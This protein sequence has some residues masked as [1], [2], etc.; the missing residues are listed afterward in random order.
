[1]ILGGGPAGSAAA[2]ALARE[3][4]LSVAIIEKDV[5]SN[6]KIGE[7]LQPIARE[8]LRRLGVWEI[9]QAAGHQPSHGTCSAWGGSTLA[10]NDFFLRLRGEGWHLD[11]RTF[12]EMLLDRAR[13]EGARIIRPATVGR[14]E[15]TPNGWRLEI[16]QAGETRRELHAKFVIDATGSRAGFARQQGARKA[17]FDQ[18]VGVYA[19]FALDRAAPLRDSFTLVETS[20]DGWWYSAALPREQLVVVHMTDADD[21]RANRLRSQERWRERAGAAPHTSRRL[22]GA[23]MI[24]VPRVALAASHLLHPVSGEGWLAVGDAASNFD[25]L[26]SYGILKALRT[27]IDAADAIRLGE[28]EDYGKKVAAEFEKY[29]RTRENYYRMERRWPERSFWKRRHGNITLDPAQL[30]RRGDPGRLP[31]L[32]FYLPTSDFETLVQLCASGLKAHELVSA[33]RLRGGAA[34]SDSRIIL[35]VQHLIETGILE[36]GEATGAGGG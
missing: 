29:L 9:F 12:D 24:A 35:A 34:Y 13:A 28:F 3:S 23:S 4:D 36:L 10:H 20:E 5:G 16:R 31:K 15:R 30:L 21:A 27:G 33:F 22:A 19:Y 6:R 26:S 32:K 25:P 1:M 8:A 14:S 18:L 2:L 7:T 11:R 17:L